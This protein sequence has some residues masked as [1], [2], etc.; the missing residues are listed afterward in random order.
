MVEPHPSVDST[1]VYVPKSSSVADTIVYRK[2]A[3]GINSPSLYTSIVKGSDPL[4]GTQFIRIVAVPVKSGT[5]ISCPHVNDIKNGVTTG[6]RC[7][8][9]M[10]GLPKIYNTPVIL[11]MFHYLFHSPHT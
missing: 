4:N 8:D 5:L 3:P 7:G 11:I 2:P 10:F 6:G 9:A 1:K